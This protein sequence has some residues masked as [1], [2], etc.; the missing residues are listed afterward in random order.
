[1]DE[2]VYPVDPRHNQRA[3]KKEVLNGQLPE[4]SQ[5]FLHLNQFQGMA[6]GDVDGV[7]LKGDGGECTTEL[8]CLFV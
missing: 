2:G 6:S 1:M 4:D 3:T 7:F 5:A 8:I